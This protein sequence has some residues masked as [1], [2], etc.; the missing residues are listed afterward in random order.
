[1]GQRDFFPIAFFLLER[2]KGRAFINS[3]NQNVCPTALNKSRWA[4]L[5][6]EKVL[7]SFFKSGKHPL[8]RFIQIG[9]IARGTLFIKR[10]TLFFCSRRGQTRRVKARRSSRICRETVWTLLLPK[11]FL[12][13]RL[14]I[15][16]YCDIILNCIKFAC[17]S[18]QNC[19]IYNLFTKFR[20]QTS[21]IF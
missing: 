8:F 19:R 20:E 5:F 4:S 12:E 17:R 3:F 10:E 9:S 15:G 2:R 6:S 21:M 13:K 18:A 14:T 11:F 16:S 7:S 1:M